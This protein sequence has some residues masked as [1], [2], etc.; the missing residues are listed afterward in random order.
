MNLDILS[1]REAEIARAY[2]DGGT[3]HGI[4]EAIGIAP[5]T[6]WTHLATIYR[7]LEVSS[8]VELFKAL[9]GDDTPTRDETDQAAIIS[10]LALSLE[11]ALNR[12]RVL[13][14][15]L[16][17]ISRSEGRIDEVIE[18]LL[19]YALE[20]CDAEF[21]MLQSYDPEKGFEVS[22]SRGIP[23]AFLDWWEERGSY[24]PSPKTGIGRMERSH[25]VVNIPDVR[26]ESIYRQNDPLRQAT[27]V[28]GGARSF[29]A[30][31]ML[32]GARLIGAFTIYRQTL[33]PFDDQTVQLARNFA[34]QSAIA[35][36]NARM[37]S[38]LRSQSETS[39]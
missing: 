28:L 31:P 20:L 7:K 17:I 13:G 37:V 38:A 19:G 36:E 21:G 10:E 22:Y 24:K 25:E 18:E 4:A 5:S 35:V 29:I 16:R 23:Q 6:V 2:A 1:A 34:D 15:V 26:A 14:E 12:E 11:E 9:A 39:V 27:A 8:K 33:R 3:Y 30:I 32:A